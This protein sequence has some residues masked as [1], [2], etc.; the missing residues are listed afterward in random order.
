MSP[1]PTNAG[2]LLAPKSSMI[3]MRIILLA[4]SIACV[5]VVVSPRGRGVVARKFTDARP[6]VSR[7]AV[8]PESFAS[9][10]AVDTWES[11]SGAMP[12]A[13]DGAR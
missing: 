6:S 7:R 2:E 10:G 8:D 3:T 5:A 9:S 4:V 12:G 11:E 13:S 1:R